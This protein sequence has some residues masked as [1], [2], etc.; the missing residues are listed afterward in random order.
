MINI[1]KRLVSFIFGVTIIP[2]VSRFN[3]IVTGRIPVHDLSEIHVRNTKL[4]ANRTEL[5]KLLP[6]GG[7]VAELGVNNGDFSKEIIAVNNPRKLHLVDI[8]GDSSD[9]RS[10]RSTVEMIVAQMPLGSSANVHIGLST[11]VVKGFEDRYFDWIY[12]DTD[13]TYKTT[14]AE[15]ESYASKMVDGGIIA[16]H[17]YA[18]TNW[19]GVVRFGVIEAVHEFCVKHEWELVYLTVE[20]NNPSFAIRKILPHQGA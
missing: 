8:W 15:L 17:D 10:K 20:I 4:V 16:G 7:V 14:I 18:R 6:K 11:E 12:V 3:A 13:H 9:D 5:L 1:L 2:I 19:L